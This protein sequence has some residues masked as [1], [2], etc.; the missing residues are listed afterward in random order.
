[1]TGDIKLKWKK[2]IPTQMYLNHVNGDMEINDTSSIDIK[3]SSLRKTK[4]GR[5]ISRE[6][7]NK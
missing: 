6:K 1:M 7:K 5:R 3:Y 4:R 2:M